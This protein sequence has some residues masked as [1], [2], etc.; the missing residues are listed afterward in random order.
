[1]KSKLS[2]LTPKA[3]KQIAYMEKKAD[4]I[5]KEIK[6]FDTES[7]RNHY[8][9]AML[10]WESVLDTRDELYE[11]MVKQ[12]VALLSSVMA[13][14]RYRLMKKEIE[15]LP[16]TKWDDWKFILEGLEKFEEDEKARYL[17]AKK[18]KI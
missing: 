5:Y 13:N 6:A 15:K 11:V 1:M 7:L 17:K 8:V 9:A 14:S 4:Q 18:V 12:A 2:K 16:K 3:K 10:N